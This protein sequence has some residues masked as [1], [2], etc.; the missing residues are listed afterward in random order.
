[1]RSA[2]SCIIVR[3]VITSVICEDAAAEE[4]PARLSD[5]LPADVAGGMRVGAG[6]GGGEEETEGDLK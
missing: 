1:M 5:P 4:I 2:D 6:G 3:Q